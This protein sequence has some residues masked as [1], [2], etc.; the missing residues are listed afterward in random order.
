M[1]AALA[2]IDCKTSTSYVARWA[3]VVDEYENRAYEANKDTLEADR[4]HLTETLR[5]AQSIL[6]SH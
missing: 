5:R 1:T 6:T 3:A 4:Q 2:D